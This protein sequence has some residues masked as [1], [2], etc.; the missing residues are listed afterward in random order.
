MFRAV[1]PKTLSVIVTLAVDLHHPHAQWKVGTVYQLGAGGAN[2]TCNT[3]VV[4]APTGSLKVRS[5][6][7]PR[8]LTHSA[9][10][11]C[12]FLELGGKSKAEIVADRYLHEGKKR[13]LRIQ[14]SK[15]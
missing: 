12:L 1:E 8:V 6:S 4:T 11:P 10:T 13:P 2:L 7:N 14:S 3:H 5:A 15:V 9:L